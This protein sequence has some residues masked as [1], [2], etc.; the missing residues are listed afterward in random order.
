M[1]IDININPL[2]YE[3]FDIDADLYVNIGARYSSKTYSILQQIVLDCLTMPGLGVVIFRHTYATI[4][5]SVYAD[6]LSIMRDMFDLVKSQ[7]YTATKSPL[8]I[9][10]VTGSFV[11]FKG[12]DDA[13]K[14]KG[15]SNV[16]QY[17]IE[18]ASDIS[19]SDFDTIMLSIR[20][21]GYKH[22]GYIASNPVPSV[23]GSPHWL[24]DTFFH[25]TPPLNENTAYQDEQLG[26][27]VVCRSNYKA[28]VYTPKK[29]IDILEGY[30]YS[31]PP[32]YKMW[33]EGL[34]ATVEG[35][36]LTSWRVVSET[37]P[38]K[39]L[40]GYGLDFG[41]S[42]DPAAMTKVWINE[43]ERI[44]WIKP[45]VYQTGLTN[46]DLITAIGAHASKLDRIIADSAEPKSI[47][48]I[49]R[50]GFRR[51]EGAKKRANYKSDMANVLQGYEIRIVDGGYTDKAR[52]ELSTWAW[53][54]D[55]NG[56][57]LPK[58]TDGN[59]HI[60][61]SIIMAVHQHLD[62]RPVNRVKMIQTYM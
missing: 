38:A 35:V 58:P 39:G 2:F 57:Q 54:K 59:D 48:E 32:L 22:K 60:I 11:T 21:D 23:P 10:F 20:G 34:F 19:R 6:L 17:F 45:L 25:N 40:I 44:L 47:E 51:I 46:A 62:K 29:Y 61:D 16:H 15:L 24:E 9:E 18:E 1:D 49:Y 31:N 41:Y 33:V 12:L 26:N 5:D 3:Q 30:K 7:H 55:K 36:I 27:V 8:Y 13:E 28:N 4:K 56:N 50:A 52:N 53:M 42:N 14:V 37:P 43:A